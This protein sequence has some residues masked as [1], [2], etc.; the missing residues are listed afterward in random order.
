MRIIIIYIMILIIEYS[1]DILELIWNSY[2]RYWGGIKPRFHP[3]NYLQK[4]QLRCIKITTNLPQGLNNSSKIAFR[5]QYIE[6]TPKEC[7]QNL[8]KQL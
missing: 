1:Y 4:D 7:L 8:L 6:C 5:Q 3:A 2:G